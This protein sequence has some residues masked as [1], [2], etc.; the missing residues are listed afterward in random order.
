MKFEDLDYILFLVGYA[1]SGLKSGFTM[2]TAQFLDVG[3]SSVNLDMLAPTGDDTSDNVAVQTLD[4]FGREVATYLWINWAGEGGDQ[5]AWVDDN[6]DV[7]TGVSFDPGQ[8]LWVQGS[9]S[10]QGLQSA[11]KVGTSD[12]VINL[13]TGFTAGGNP[14]PV[15]VD[16]QDIVAG[17]DDASDN[18][19]L[20]TLDAYGR[21]VATYLWI[22]W[23]GEGGD[24]EAWV[25]DN[26]EIVE[27][28]SYPAG[29]GLW[30]QGSNDAQYVRF[31]APE[32]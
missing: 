2:T 20:Q 12:V 22:N 15:A 30:I 3:S 19:A 31:P 14:F 29:Q 18:I 7:V 13:C 27:G 1:Q 28:V 5:E 32:L 9:L 11:G 4:A 17:G 10:G 25:D 21:E 8:G 24:Q 6:Y 23:A 26:Y 16:L